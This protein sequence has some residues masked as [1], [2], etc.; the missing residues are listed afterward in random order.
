VGENGA[1][2][3]QESKQIESRKQIYSTRKDAKVFEEE[4]KSR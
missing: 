3:H 2:T 4:K 1:A